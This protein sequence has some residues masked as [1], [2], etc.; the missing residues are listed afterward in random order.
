[1]DSINITTDEKIVSLS[2]ENHSLFEFLLSDEKVK[3]EKPIASHVIIKADIR[4]S[5]IINNTMRSRGL[6][7]ASYF[8]LNFFDPISAVLSEYG[9]SKVF[10]EG[11]AIILSI[12]ENEDEKQ[13]N[14]SVARA[15]GLAIRILQIVGRYNEKNKENNFPILELGIGICYFQGPPTFLFD[16]NYKIMISQAIN[17]ADRMSSCDKMLRKVFKSQND[18]FNLFVFENESEEV[19]DPA[20]DDTT[21]RYNVNG[22]ELNEEGFNKLT[23]EINLQTFTYPSENDENVKLYTGKVPLMNGNYQRI[24]IREAAIH[25]VIPSAFD[26]SGKVSK[27]YY[28]VCTHQNIYNLTEKQY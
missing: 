24:A 20:I 12:F 4:G 18:I 17:Q 13:M 6:N 9:A 2:R 11:D 19:I 5:I 21:Y 25:R 26:I 23:K 27:K 8:S 28:E 7:P 10:I 16:G 1:M 14:Y 15:C 3:E 22:I